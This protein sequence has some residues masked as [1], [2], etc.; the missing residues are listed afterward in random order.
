MSLTTGLLHRYFDVT[1]HNFELSLHAM[2]V[3]KLEF[4][5]PAVMTIG[6]RID[7]ASLAKYARLMTGKSQSNVPELVKGVIEGETRVI[8]AGMSMEE[9]FK[10]DII[11]FLMW[12][13]VSACAY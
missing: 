4:L 6:P 10:V 7:E 2:S 3:E 11:E 5:L 12:Y 8:A 13:F 9:I 1:P